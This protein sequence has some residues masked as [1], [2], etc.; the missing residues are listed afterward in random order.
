MKPARDLSGVAR[1]VFHEEELVGLS[2][3]DFYLLWALKEAWLKRAGLGVFDMK[4]APCF[5]I[6]ETALGFTVTAVPQDK[7]AYCLYE[8]TGPDCEPYALAVCSG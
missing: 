7:L 1:K 3:R 8:I 2:H 4:K 6:E 5:D